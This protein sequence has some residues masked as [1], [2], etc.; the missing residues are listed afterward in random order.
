[1]WAW[2]LMGT[3]MFVALKIDS[4]GQMQNGVGDG[5]CEGYWQ[6]CNGT[7]RYRCVGDTLLSGCGGVFSGW[8]DL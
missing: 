8:R 7:G 4:K 3:E 1:M 2:F 5:R 6:G